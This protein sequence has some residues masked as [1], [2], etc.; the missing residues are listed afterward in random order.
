MKIV[1]YLLSA[2][3][4]L[5][6][7]ACNHEGDEIVIA[8]TEPAFA[9]HADVVVN[10]STEA[11]DFTLVWSPAKFGYKTDVE[12][13]VGAEYGEQSLSLGTTSETYFSTTNSHLF[14]SFGIEEAG[15][16][17]ITFN[18][19]AVTPA[20]ETAA[21][22]PMVVKF[23]YDIPVVVEEAYLYIAGDYQ[24]WD[25]ALA[26][27]RLKL[28]ANNVY[29]G[30]L[31]LPEGGTY[32]FKF[33]A[34]QS[35]DGPNYGLKDGVLSTEADAGNFKADAAGLYYIVFDAVNAT[36]EMTPITY[37]GLIGDA[38]GGW[39]T[40]K[41]QFEFDAEN[42]V[43]VAN[44][45]VESGKNFKIRFNQVWD[46]T[47]LG[48]DVADLQ[49]KGSD[50][51]ATETGSGVFTLN[52]F[53]FPYTLNVDVTPG[54]G[55]VTPEPEP[56]PTDG[57]Y[58]LV[59]GFNGW[60]IADTTY[61]FTEAASNGYL[62][63]KNVAMTMV[64]YTVDGEGW[65]IA[66][67]HNWS[68]PNYSS[69][70]LV[71]L[72]VPTLF[73]NTSLNSGLAAEG[74]YDFY[75]NPTTK[76]VIVV[77]AGAADPTG[78]S[79]PEPEPAGDVYHLV[80]AFNGWDIADTTY[81][82]KEAAN[83]G[84]LTLKNVAMTNAVNFSTDGFKVGFNHNWDVSYTAEAA[85]A[86]GVPTMLKNAFG[87]TGLPADGNYD[88][89]FNPETKYIIVVEAGAADPTGGST[90]DEPEEHDGFRI[91][92]ENKAGYSPIAVYAWGE[93]LS[94]ASFFG[95]WPGKV[96]TDYE[97]INGVR[98]YYAD[99]DASLAGEKF[100][101]IFNNNNGG[102][103][104]GDQA[105][106]FVLDKDFFFVA[107]SGIPA[108]EADTT[109]VIPTFCVAG[110]GVGWGGTPMTDL[111]E[112]LHVFKNATFAVDNK[113]KIK[114]PDTW[115]NCFGAPDTNPITIGTPFDAATPGEDIVIGTAG[116]YDI[117]FNSATKKICV[118]N[119]GAAS[120]F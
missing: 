101:I 49:F 84:Y 111:S 66:F 104:T 27:S 110:D 61:E 105:E 73:K 31:N 20:G 16:Y 79:T 99:L 112:T 51:A 118:V 59:G 106:W 96:M 70:G 29:E 48:G 53:D 50:I 3:A 41:A 102:Q 19:S 81:E 68:N 11:E 98:Y 57:V 117:Y 18:L 83:N 7:G 30:L 119:T 87:N 100:K 107:Q 1:K 94:D 113:F 43:W 46:L 116:T 2:A 42:N 115:D 8:Q 120:P 23:V 39:D 89:Y 22:K 80:G 71:E 109:P 91:Y 88:F 45:P 32:E 47:D 114:Y 69:E 75:F 44:A 15:E 55:P 21:A 56:E 72:G 6:L 74:N 64:D 90:P 34:Q 14:S 65:K 103:Q 85:L 52:I 12:Y 78:G 54:E 36:V 37:V 10:K 26:C 38:V 82:F 24:G 17:A 86:L 97:D 95:G 33:C 67:N 5:S 9:A 28:N 63:V 60:D 35:W 25:P 93:S 76:Y 108:F 13:T 77:E 4:L 92:V 40:D 58:H 62:T